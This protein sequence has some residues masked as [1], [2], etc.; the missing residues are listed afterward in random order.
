LPVLEFRVD[1]NGRPTYFNAAG[2][3]ITGYSNL[4][5][6]RAAG[7][8]LHESLQSVILVVYAEQLKR[9]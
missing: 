5:E 7:K 8:D 6:L 2:A 4:D 9:D 3:A 1:A